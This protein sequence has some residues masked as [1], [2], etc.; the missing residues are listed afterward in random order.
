MLSTKD[1]GVI[2][3]DVLRAAFGQ[4]GYKSVDTTFEE[5]F[6]GVEIIQL[7]ARFAAPLEDSRALIAA[8]ATI[9]ARIAAQGDSR[10]VFLSQMT[11]RPAEEEGEEEDEDEAATG[12]A[13]R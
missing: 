8:N 4:R 7:R 10:F 13:T 11:P 3:D 1:V 2:A 9:R 5:D 6:D 12:I